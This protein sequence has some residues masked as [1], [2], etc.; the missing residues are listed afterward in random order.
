MSD[1][2]R[3]SN[4][5]ERA[6]MTTI[7]VIGAADTGRAPMAAALLRR[8]LVDRGYDWPVGSAGVLGHDGDPA[9]VEARD[10][11]AHMGLDIGAHAAR[12]LT[13]ELVAQSALLL[14]LD[15]GTALVARARFA[16]SASRIH[17]L[18]ALAGRQR[19]IPDPFRMQIGAWMTYAH[20]IAEL[21]EAALPQIVAALPPTTNDQRPTTNDD[22]H[23]DAQHPILDTRYSAVERIDRLLRT[24][25]EMPGVLDWAAARA[26]I[27]ADLDQIAA[28]SRDVGD[29]ASAYVGLLR[30]ALTMTPAAPSHGQLMAL[31]DA[32]S[33]LNGPIGQADLND[34][35]AR[36]GGW[37]AL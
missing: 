34:L 28:T 36:L 29:L 13:D 11:M 26:Q 5:A 1:E 3:L 4:N 21:L 19:D 31:R 37:A 15:N 14:A 32:A 22:A 10:T 16:D 12:S 30:A 18:G 35:S 2:P 23:G 25:A 9:E 24:A 33:R 20:E 17:T 7:L 8:L 27:E 6:S